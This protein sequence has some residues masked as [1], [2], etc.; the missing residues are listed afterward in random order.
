[1]FFR[2]K[3]MVMPQPRT[4]YTAAP[5]F[6]IKIRFDIFFYILDSNRDLYNILLYYAYIIMCV[7]IYTSCPFELFQCAQYIIHLWHKNLTRNTRTHTYLSLNREICHVN[8]FYNN[9]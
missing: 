9:L 7:P 2:V 5:L 4:I 3:Y 6:S 1:M 8:I